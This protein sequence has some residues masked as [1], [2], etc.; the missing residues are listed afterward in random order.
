MPTYTYSCF[1]CE[2]LF[3][4]I[5]PWKER[6]EQ[7]IFCESTNIARRWPTPSIR[8]A[9]TFAAGRGM[10]LDQCGGRTEEVDGLVALAQKHGY[11]PSPNDIYMP[12]LARPGVG[13]GDPEAF[14]PVNE[15]EGYIKRVLRRRGDGCEDLG[16]KPVLTGPPPKKC[17]APDL[18]E[19]I[20][21]K[22]IKANPDLAHKDQRKL[23]AEIIERH[24]HK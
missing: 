7:C 17:L 20:R 4:A 11:T 12:T 6:L 5:H 21:R 15:G 16:I 2:H 18:V 10:L 14:I 13:R 8:T 24:S 22:K 1:D 19:E 23:R 3:E 9:T